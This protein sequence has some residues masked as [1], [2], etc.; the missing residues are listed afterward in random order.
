[1]ITKTAE[2]FLN[3]T[4]VTTLIHQPVILGSVTTMSSCSY[5][6][7]DI[8]IYSDTLQHG[9]LWYY[10]IGVFPQWKRPFIDFSE[11][12]EHELGSV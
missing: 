9:C 11:S 2:K 8:W 4:F 10:D 1:M 7:C 12:L 6:K 5:A 3:G